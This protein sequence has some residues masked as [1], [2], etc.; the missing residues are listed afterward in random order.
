MFWE[1]GITKNELAWTSDEINMLSD[2]CA[3][4]SYAALLM[5]MNDSFGQIISKELA[6]LVNRPWKLRNTSSKWREVQSLKTFFRIRGITVWLKK[7][8]REREAKKADE[9]GENCRK[10]CLSEWEEWYPRTCG[11]ADLWW[12]PGKAIPFLRKGLGIRRRCREVRRCRGRS[13]SKLL[14]KF[15]HFLS[16]I[17]SKTTSEE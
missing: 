7:V 11:R 17:R 2:K 8:W 15:F 6:T 10:L 4:C 3:V 12:G 16:E 13:L 14:S 5:E 1:V 9:R